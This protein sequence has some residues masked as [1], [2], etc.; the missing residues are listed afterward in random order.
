LLLEKK[1]EQKQSGIQECAV[2]LESR[3]VLFE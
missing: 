2:K 1:K 3:F